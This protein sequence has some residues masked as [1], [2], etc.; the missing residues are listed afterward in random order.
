ATHVIV[1]EVH[2]RDLHTDFLLTLLRRV[3]HH[4]ADLK[5][6]LMSATVDPSAFQGYFNGIRT[7]SIPGKTNYPIEELFL[8]DLLPQ[9][10]TQSRQAWRDARRQQWSKAS[11][12][13]MGPLPGVPQGSAA[14][15][16]AFPHLPEDVVWDIAD[17]HG[18]MAQ[19]IDYD[20]TASLVQA[21]HDSGKEGGVLIFMPGWFEITQTIERLEKCRCKHQLAIHPLHSR[22]PTWEQQAIF[23]P[24]P[25][26]RRKIVISTVLAETSITV[27][28][29]VYV[30]DPGRA[31]TTFFNETSMISALRTVWYSKAN[32]FQRRGRAGRCRPGVW[33]RLF[34][35]CQWEAMEE[36]ALPEMQR[37]PLEEL[38][39]EVSSLGLGPPA[40]FLRE[41]ISP[42]KG[43]VVR[44]ALKL[45]HGLGAVTDPT[46]K[47]L[48]PLGAALAKIQVHPML[49]KMLLLAVPFKCYHMMV[50][51][52]ASLGYK[53]PFLCPMGL[54]KEANQAKAA[55]ADGSK[56][57]L[58]ALVNAYE[59]WKRG[60]AGF[61]RQNFLSHQ[62][63]DYI[64]RLR[65]DLL[66]ASK[67]VLRN[68]PQDHGDPVLLADS[69]KAVLTAG[70]YPN[71]SLLRRRGKGHTIQGL[72]VVVH[73][74]SVNSKEEWTQ[75]VFYEIQETTD[76][77]MYDTTVVGLAPLLLFAPALKEVH[78]GRRVVFELSPKS[79]VAVD[80]KVADVLQSLRGLVA[81]F[82]D[83]SVGTTPTPL[84]LDTAQGLSRLFAEQ[85]GGP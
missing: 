26:G 71:V 30:I 52:C 67:D 4:R 63:M 80:V 79:H 33:Y 17:V 39:M 81:S 21:I 18:E 85:A 72:P 59:G 7:V 46:G 23:R 5:I 28:D 31:R 6:I 56:S 22:I 64:H 10:S 43:D 74:G 29:I 61:A 12:F 24:S 54:E 70:L 34:S 44:H 32:G 2:E 35:S 49:A 73:P 77:F 53:S 14:I 40:D 41:A 78:R 58:I 1:D 65:E 83:R 37:S 84:M 55:L 51:I 15:R 62:T 82:V 76:R 8:E 60:K 75:V 3:L 19:N 48:T 57:D 38:C 45:L 47:T 69:C 36:Y 20:L 50:T 9:L 68:V 13:A 16:A 42:P 27:E 25:A 66:S 11:A